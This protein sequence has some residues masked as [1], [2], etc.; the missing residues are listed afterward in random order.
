[1]TASAGIAILVAADGWLHA[2]TMTAP[3][4]PTDHIK[5][6]VPVAAGS[7]A[8]TVA[9]LISDPLGKALAVS[10]VI[11]N[12]PGARGVPGTQHLVRSPSDGATIGMVSS[13][14][15]INPSI[16][17]SM[18][19]DSNKDITAISVL[20]SRATDIRGRLTGGQSVLRLAWLAH[21]TA[22]VGGTPTPDAC[23]LITSDS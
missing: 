11:E 13:N 19:F 2:Q 7:T 8:D 3:P 1:M 15:V 22:A 6:I 18:P 17:R 12:R 10:V 20:G 5:M 16:S 21:P 9:R 23:R 4:Y 14:Y